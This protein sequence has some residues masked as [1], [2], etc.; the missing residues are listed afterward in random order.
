MRSAIERASALVAFRTDGA[1]LLPKVDDRVGGRIMFSG[2]LAERPATACRAMKGR[3]ARRFKSFS[4]RAPISSQGCLA[5]QPLCG[6]L[7][8]RWRDQLIEESDLERTRSL[9]RLPLEHQ[10]ERR[11]HADQAN[12]PYRASKS[13]GDMPAARTGTVSS[14][15]RII[16]ADP[17][18]RGNASSKPPPRAKPWIAATL[19]QG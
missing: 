13:G 8:F 7:D 14:D 15:T 5:A 1:V 12:G 11:P 16:G 2:T 10:L 6:R 18:G 4:R 3:M 17:V 9:E 19:G